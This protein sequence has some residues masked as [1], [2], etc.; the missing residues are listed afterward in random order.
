MNQKHSIRCEQW[1]PESGT[2]LCEAGL[3]IFPAFSMSG[4]QADFSFNYMDSIAPLRVER[5]EV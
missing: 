1:R 2:F 3:E 5:K 4:G